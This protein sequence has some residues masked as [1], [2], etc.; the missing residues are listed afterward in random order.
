M[1]LYCGQIDTSHIERLLEIS[2]YGDPQNFLAGVEGRILSQRRDNALAIEKFFS[3]I[4]A[5]SARI[6]VRLLAFGRLAHF[7]GSKWEAF[8]VSEHHPPD[9]EWIYSV[10]HPTCYPTSHSLREERMSNPRLFDYG[11]PRAYVRAYKDTIEAGEYN[12]KWL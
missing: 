4:P 6:L 11:V 8:G 5:H 3:Y 10:D 9:I 1:G 2:G 7:V 12:A